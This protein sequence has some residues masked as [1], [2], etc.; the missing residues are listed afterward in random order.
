METLKSNFSE[1]ESSFSF[2]NNAFKAAL[3]DAVARWKKASTLD[4]E[5]LE[6]VSREDSGKITTERANELEAQAV[7][8]DLDLKNSIFTIT[9]EYSNETKHIGGAFALKGVATLIVK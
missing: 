8:K 9:H 4:K 3:K 5:L 7:A 1:I 6:I 2:E